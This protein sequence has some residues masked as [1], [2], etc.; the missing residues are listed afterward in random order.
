MKLTVQS[1]GHISPVKVSSSHLHW[2]ARST[3]KPVIQ[4]RASSGDRT[5]A[6]V[7]AIPDTGGR[8]SVRMSLGSFATHW[9]GSCCVLAS[10]L[11]GA[12]L[13]LVVQGLMAI[14]LKV[15]LFGALFPGDAPIPD[16][17]NLVLEISRE[18]DRWSRVWGFAGDFHINCPHPGRVVDATVTDDKVRLILEMDIQSGSWARGGRAR[19][20]VSLLRQP[21]GEFSGSFTGEFRGV[22]VSG[23]VTAVRK[24]PPTTPPPG[25]VPPKPG[26][27]PRLLLRRDDL[28]VLREKVKT[29]LGQAALAKMGWS[30]QKETDVVGLGLKYQ[31]TGDR[32][33]AQE[34]ITGV[35]QLMRAGL[36]C[37]QYGNNV[38]DRAEKMALAFDLCYDALPEE[39]KRR[40]RRY[41]LFIAHNMSGIINARCTRASTGTFAVTGLL[42]STQELP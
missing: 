40:V 35:E 8:S 28:P 30:N 4:P 34:A 42:Q 25:F 14:E 3:A 23:K 2:T 26:E 12:L 22:T 39:F 1:S 15:T 7:E 20:D 38:G 13:L 21:N 32:R 24:P 31:L 9:G 11:A 41:L 27:H 16:G 36:H 37:D 18:S 10:W 29:P 19:N 6:R 17:P 33:F 5:P